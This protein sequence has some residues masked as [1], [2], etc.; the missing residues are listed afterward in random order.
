MQKKPKSFLNPR[1][2][3]AFAMITGLR[4]LGE[5]AHVCGRVLPAKTLAR[6]DG[7]EPEPEDLDCFIGSSQPLYIGPTGHI[8]S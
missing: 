7:D 3:G 2:R 5:S 4:D 8:R 1:R 6:R